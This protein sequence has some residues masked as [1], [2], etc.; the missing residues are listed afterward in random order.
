MVEP[1]NPLERGDFHRLTGFPGSSGVNQFRFVEAVDGFCQG[2]IVTIPLASHRRFYPSFRQAIGISNRKI[3]RSTVR[4][5][6]Q[7]LHGRLSGIQSLLP[8]PGSMTTVTRW[9]DLHDLAN[10]LDPKGVT[11][12]VNKPGYDLM[13]RSSSAWAKRAFSVG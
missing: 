11:I 1:V 5:V 2:V 4:V 9:G 7:F 10:R 13:R 6:D 12:R 3:L 8:F